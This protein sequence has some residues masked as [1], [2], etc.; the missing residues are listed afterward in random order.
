M[1]KIKTK[2]ELKSVAD[3]QDIK[4]ESYGTCGLCF[5]VCTFIIIF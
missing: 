2:A 3:N 5:K 4:D 1:R